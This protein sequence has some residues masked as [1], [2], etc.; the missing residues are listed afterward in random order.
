MTDDKENIL[1]PY[2]IGCKALMFEWQDSVRRLG[3]DY[4]YMD[5]DGLRIESSSDT[6]D[7]DVVESLCHHCSEQLINIWIPK[8]LFTALF[9]KAQENDPELYPLEF[10]E[11]VTKIAE[12]DMK[13]A[14]LEALI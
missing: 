5:E 2:C 8:E 7:V 10:K 1:V 4:M 14:I 9:N 12:G 3:R 11:D 6:D 13:N